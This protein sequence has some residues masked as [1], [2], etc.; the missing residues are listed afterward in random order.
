MNSSR[1][2]TEATGGLTDVEKGLLAAHHALWVS[3]ALRT[4]PVDRKKV[5]PL[6]LALYAA[7]SLSEPIVEVVSSPGAMAF[8]G[9]FARHILNRTM[10]DK[11]YPFTV[12]APM[13]IKGPDRNEA[14]VREVINAL[15]AVTEKACNSSDWPSDSDVCG[16]VLWATYG[17]V[18]APIA[19][20]M[21]RQ[22]NRE[23]RESLEH[24]PLRDMENAIVDAMKDPFG[25]ST[26][27]ELIQASVDE[28]GFELARMIFPGEEEARAA[29]SGVCDWWK[30]AQRGAADTYWD[31]CITAARDVLG[32]RVPGYEKYKIWE[33][34]TVQTAYRY[35]HPSFCLVSDFPSRIV[36]KNLNYVDGSGQNRYF[37]SDGWSV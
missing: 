21:D 19:E 33:E 4:T 1:S 36:S 22:T 2:P 3:R 35:M 27:T 24:Y 26:M 15:S 7:A 9:T 6:I 37:W 28:W 32:L 20:A 17:L 12:P 25:N 11:N 13:S 31:F 30:H 18:D 23:L 34:C 8:A 16:S 10:K 29:I 5:E 14:V